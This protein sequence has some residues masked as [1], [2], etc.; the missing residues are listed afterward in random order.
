MRSRRFA[1]CAG[2]HAAGVLCLRK[3]TLVCTF[4]NERS[5]VVC[6]VAID[7]VRRDADLLFGTRV[8]YAVI[9]GQGTRIEI[10]EGID[11]DE[12]AT[13]MRIAIEA[14]QTPD[15]GNAH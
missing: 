14:A 9:E 5:V 8:R 2:Y 6:D 3:R 10:V 7:H 4:E 12:F 1:T 15:D 11:P 13:H